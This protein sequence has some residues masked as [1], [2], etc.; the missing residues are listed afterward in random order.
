MSQHPIAQR[1]YQPIWEALKLRGY[2]KV[3][4]PKPLHKRLIKAVIKEKY[5]DLGFKLLL[6]ENSQR[7]KISYNQTQSMIEFFLHKSI[8]LGDI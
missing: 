6:D 2:C 4:V 3:A 7:A 1:Q 5:Q 8:G